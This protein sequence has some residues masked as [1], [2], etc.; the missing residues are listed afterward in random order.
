[1]KKIYFAIGLLSL[2]SV[3]AQQFEEVSGTPFKDFF[4]SASAVADFNNDGFQDIF[5]TGAIDSNNNNEVDLTFNEF[6][7]NNNGT[8]A[9]QQSFET[10]AV[11]LSDVRSIDFDNDG[12]P[13]L[14]TTG[15]SYN[16][17]VNYQQYRFKNTGSG[18][19]LVEN[20]PGRIFGGLD[21]FDF[22]HDG[23]QD[24]AL[25][26]MQYV[27]NVGFT[28]YLDFY[29]NTGN[30]FTKT[31]NWMPGISNGDFKLLDIN[32]DN[33]LDY[34]VYGFDEDQNGVFNVYKNVDGS[35]V[36]SQE[37]PL[38]NDGKIAYADFNNDGFLDLIVTGQDEEY[39]GYLA[40]FQNDGTG[41]FTENKIEGE[42]I[43]GATVQVGDLNNDGY[44]DFVVKGD[45][46]N[47]DGQVKVF[48]Y[49]P[50]GNNFVKAE[51][52]N[53]YNLGS[54]GSIQIFDFDNDNKLDIMINGFD[55][56]DPDMMP[57]TK[58]YRNVSTETNQK[59]N[60]PTQLNAIDG[61]DKIVFNWNGASDDKTPENV[62]QYEL[63]VGSQS[64]KSNIA[65]YVVTTKSWYLKKE[66]LPSEIFWS[67]KSID[68][69]K[70]YSESSQEQTSVLSVSENQ[71][72]KF[73]VYPNP[74]KDILNIRSNEK[75]VSAKV[76]TISGQLLPVKLISEKT[77][78]FSG[79]AKGIYIV[80]ITLQNGKK[81]TEKVIK[82]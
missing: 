61:G 7:Q 65:K 23:K 64:G 10:N 71:A 32:N 8:F 39:N 9:V 24:Y 58:L 74:V 25:N 37:L 81:V 3:N 59:P 47:Y 33:E 82:E 54:G 55:W 57:R 80:E 1:M 77:I 29:K 28:N 36:L 17:V 73:A 12:L 20:I 44:Y 48:T 62:L 46:E 42:G 53:I 5:F 70:V 60:A 79:F 52:T 30:G 21:V 38:V 69:G 43:D 50:L 11:H 56:N 49:Q 19:E 15:L 6:Y 41:N 45:D 14:V 4:Y 13:D 35:F 27:E 34:V 67:V 2:T 22:D 66:A 16:D 26:G 18:F 63:S 51:N 78:D 40:Y 31:E 68:A 75:A 72:A 76:Y